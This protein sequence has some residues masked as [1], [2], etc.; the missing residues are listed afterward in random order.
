[1]AHSLQTPH[2]LI[3]GAQAS[4]ENGLFVNAQSATSHRVQVGRGP[5][6]MSSF[7]SK[8]ENKLDLGLLILDETF[9]SQ[10]LLEQIGVVLFSEIRAE[11]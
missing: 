10:N 11:S 5:R 3:D 7:D 1:M 9:G 6:T 4:L 2:S 8:E